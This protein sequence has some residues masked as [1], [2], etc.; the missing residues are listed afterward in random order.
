MKKNKERVI[1]YQDE[2][3]DDFMENNLESVSIPET[4]KYKRT[5][6]F[7]NFI[8]GWFYYCV[9]KPILYMVNFFSGVRYV[10]QKEMKKYKKQGCFIYSNHTNVFDAFAIQVGIVRGKRCNVI[11]LSDSYSNFLLRHVGRALGY[12]PIPDNI[13]VMRNFMDGIEFYIN[14]EHQDILIYPEAHIWPYY[15]KIRPFPSVS[16]R[17]PAKLNAPVIPVVTTYRKSKFF[18]KP[19]ITLVVGTAILPKPELTVTQNK[20]YLRNECYKQMVEI[21]ER[22]KQPEYIKY[23]KKEENN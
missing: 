6:K 23:I 11:A 3:N 9:A 7:N 2:V 16:F 17:Y 20:E 19:R 14:K 12:I 5:N 21:S 4:F 10:N 8:S 15:T 22:Y 13:K 18:K 1:Y